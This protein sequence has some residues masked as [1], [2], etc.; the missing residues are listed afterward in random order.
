M[1]QLYNGPLDWKLQVQCVVTLPSSVTLS[2]FAS[3]VKQHI[4]FGTS[5][6]SEVNTKQVH[7]A[8]HWSHV[9]G[10]VRLDGAWLRTRESDISATL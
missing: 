10:L 2:K 4:Q 1:V 7:C 3:V 5:V 8:T 9:H 6:S